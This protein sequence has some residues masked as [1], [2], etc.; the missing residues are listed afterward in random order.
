MATRSEDLRCSFCGKSQRQVR[1]LIA[2]LVT[3]AMSVLRFAT[4]FF[5]KKKM[6][7]KKQADIIQETL[8]C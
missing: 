6:A 8:T 4:K 3:S 5:R 1:K 7:R 2:G